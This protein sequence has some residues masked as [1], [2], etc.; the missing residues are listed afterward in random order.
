MGYLLVG[1][2]PDNY[3]RVSTHGLRILGEKAASQSLPQKMGK[4]R[5]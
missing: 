5:R 1:E 3:K 4:K 2:K